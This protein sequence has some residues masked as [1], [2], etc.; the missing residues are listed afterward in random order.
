M[1][2]AARNMSAKAKAVRAKHKAKVHASPEWAAKKAAVKAKHAALVK[3]ARGVGSGGPSQPVKKPSKGPTT[4]PKGGLGRGGPKV[5]KPITP[6]SDGPPGGP[7]GGGGNVG[8]GRPGLSAG[9]GSGRP[10]KPRPT[11]SV[12]YVKPKRKKIKI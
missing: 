10:S 3:G 12:K 4:P 11:K 7:P 8:R 2:P 1:K 5:P 6:P 9:P